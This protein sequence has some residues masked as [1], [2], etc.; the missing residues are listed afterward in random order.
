VLREDRAGRAVVRTDVLEGRAVSGSLGV[1]VDDQVD[2]ADETAEVMRLH[3]DG[4]DAVEA[5]EGL[6]IQRFHVDVEQVRHSEILRSGDTLKRADDGGGLGP[7][8]EVAQ[9]QAAGHRIWIGVVVQQN[10]DTVRVRQIPL[11]LLYA[12]PR[13]REM[14]GAGQRSV[15]QVRERQTGD[16]WE[17]RSQHLLPFGAARVADLQEEMGNCS[18]IAQNYQLGNENVGTLAVFGSKRMDYKRIISIVNHT[19]K[20]VSKLISENQGV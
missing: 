8:E 10:Q 7:V 9:G 17:T 6:M 19:A 18:L 20:I 4:G 5:G 12:R 15:E 13:H 11:V 3:I 16:L 14:Q 2:L 1:V